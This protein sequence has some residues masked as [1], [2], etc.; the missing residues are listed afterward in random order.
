MNTISE[1]KK[2]FEKIPNVKKRILNHTIKPRNK[3]KYGNQI[4]RYSNSNSTLKINNQKQQHIHNLTQLNDDFQSLNNENNERCT[5]TLLLKDQENTNKLNNYEKKIKEQQNEIKNLCQKNKQLNNEVETLKKSKLN[6]EKNNEIK[7][8]VILKEKNNKIIELE[9][10]NS[11]KQKE[12]EYLKE[13]FDLIQ[14]E[15]KDT[16]EKVIT[17]QK[18]KNNLINNNTEK[19]NQIENLKK[20]NFLIKKKLEKKNNILINNDN[21]QNNNFKI[22]DLLDENKSLKES[23]NNNKIEFDNLFVKLNNQ[24]LDIKQGLNKESQIKEYNDLKTENLSL[25]YILKEKIN[26]IDTLNIRINFMNKEKKYLEIQKREIENR[27]KEL[28]QKYNLLIQEK[29]EFENKRKE[30]ENELKI[31]EKIKQENHNLNMQNQKLLN[32]IQEKQS[33]LNDLGTSI[34][35]SILSIEKCDTNELIYLIDKNKKN[36]YDINSD[37]NIKNN[38]FNTDNRQELIKCPLPAINASPK[39]VYERPAIIGLNNIG[40]TGFMNATIQCFSQTKGLTNYFLEPKNKNQIVTNNS[41]GQLQLSPIYLDLVQKLW[42]KNYEYNSF[43]PFDFINIVEKMNPLFKKGQPGDSKDFIIFL[44]EQFHKELKESKEN[45]R[46]LINRNI[47]I[48]HYD[49]QETMNYFFEEFMKET[50][51]IS[52][53]FVGIIE[54]TN[55]CLNCKINYNSRGMNNPIFYNFQKI[56]C[57]YF[58]FRRN[59]L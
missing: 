4:R 28:Q 52:D 22:E 5:K 9:K 56:N 37:N 40:A 50:S 46:I 20:E 48:N 47:Y 49:K 27:E 41:R 23:I 2:K 53:L 12:L 16:K 17:I 38:L 19:Y 15:L 3:Q 25:N 10:T 8:N 35:E 45:N 34:K 58:S 31:N 24:L 43:S 18:E 59:K 54:T 36:N 55:V 33:K 44:L 26:E 57:I 42:P 29:N 30:F 21:L 1:N 6:E 13:Q 39:R 32:E 14:Q 11:D 7:I 51:I